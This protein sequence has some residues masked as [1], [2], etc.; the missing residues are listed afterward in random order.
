MAKWVYLFKEGN[1]EM[2]NLLGGKGANLAE[3]TG[4]GLPIP[5]GFTVTTEACTDYY[6][7]GKQISDEIK[8]QIFA[9]LAQLEELQ[10]KTFGDTNDPLL[11]SVRSGAR[12]SM[13]GMMDTILNLGLN[14]EVVDVIARKS[15]NPRWAWDCYRR[16]I[17]M[18]SDVVM[19]VGKKYFEELIDK[20]KADK[21]V[22]FDVDLTADDLKELAGQFKESMM[23]VASSLSAGFSIENALASSVRELSV[24]Y[25]KDGLIV[26]EFAFMVQQ[27]GMNRPVEQVLEE[28]ARRSGLEDVKNFAEVFSVAKRSSGNVGGIMRHTAEIIR[29][30]MQVREEILTMTASR[31]FEQKIMNLIPFF[32]VFYVESASPG[33]FDQMYNTNMGRMLMSGCL[34]VYLISYVLAKKILDIEV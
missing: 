26:R 12:A 9:A 1:A 21:G 31:Q 32:I 25:G 33:F 28:F 13:P 34:A 20:M 27:I 24:L 10:G 4:L 29:D 3:M 6:N 8:E 15:D 16:F 7:N 23:I 22:T 11:V 19:E 17:Q 14:E 30:K 18:Y 5:Q 2:R